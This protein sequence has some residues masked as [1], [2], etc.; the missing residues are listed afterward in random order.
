MC[1]ATRSIFYLIRIVFVYL[2]ITALIISEGRKLGASV[3]TSEDSYFEVVGM[4]ARSV[5]IVSQISQ[6]IVRSCEKYMTQLP[7]GYPQRVLVI[8]RPPSAVESMANYKT[9][10]YSG[11]FVQI[12]FKWDES[13]DLETVCFG[14]T[15]AFVCRYAIYQYGSAGPENCKY[16]PISAL[17]SQSYLS[18]RSAQTD[19]YYEQL[20][21]TGVPDL[22]TLLQLPQI[23]SSKIAT[24]REGYWLLRTFRD[25]SMDR[26][27]IA[28]LIEYSIAGNNVGKLLQEFLLEQSPDANDIENWWF[29]SMGALA[30]VPFDRVESMH[31][32][33]GWIRDAVD[34]TAFQKEAGRDVENIRALWKL[35]DTPSI[36]EMLSARQAL[37][38]LRIVR[39]NPAYFN[40]ARSLALMYENILHSENS[41]EYLHAWTRYLGDFEDANR[42]QAQT[43][44]LL[45]NYKRN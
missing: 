14:L 22:M 15:E 25:Q 41:Y 12:D 7:D 1:Y 2:L 4:D 26:K 43:C 21:T 19:T 33:E 3:L 27:Q 38:A 5:G 8:L 36:R 13:L 17:S 30:E 16:W 24:G 37:I 20:R 28:R 42:L 9:Q 35:R 6:H 11:G 44:E 39:V 34:F 32:S 31:V 23:N 10:V 29:A 18:L 45:E 40:A